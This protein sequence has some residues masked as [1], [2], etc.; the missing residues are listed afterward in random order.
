MD[1]GGK[2]LA[3][4]DA[5]GSK[6]PG[7]PTGGGVRVRAALNFLEKRLSAASALHD[8]DWDATVAFARGVRDDEAASVRDRIRASELLAG[9]SERGIDV[10]EKVDKIERLDSGQNTENVG[11]NVKYIGGVD[12]GVL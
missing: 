5:P 11:H 12:P 2:N 6:T 9:L 3:Q 7:G 1:D 4:T 10:A 8:S